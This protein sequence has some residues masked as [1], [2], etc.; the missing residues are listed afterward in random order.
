MYISLQ[1]YLLS[2]V[3]CGFPLWFSLSSSVIIIVECRCDAGQR[4]CIGEISLTFCFYIPELPPPLLSPT[5]FVNAS[6]FHYFK[7]VQMK[8]ELLLSGFLKEI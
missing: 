6:L 1:L 7:V 2:L 4:L 3:K 5:L 8:S